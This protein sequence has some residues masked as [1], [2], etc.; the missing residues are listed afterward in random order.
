MKITTIKLS[1]NKDVTLTAYVQ[2]QSEEMKNMT[3]KKAILIFPGGG[4]K[5]CSDREAEPI[6]LL[7]LSKGYNAFILRYSVKEHAKWPK[8]LEDA[9]QAMAYLKNHSLELDIDQDRIAVIGFSAGGHLASQL[10]TSGINRPN[11]LILGYPAVLRDT[12]NG[13]DYPK[14]IVDDKTPEAFVFHTVEDDVV[15]QK[16]SLY[17]ANAFAEKK[18][19]LELHIFRNGP[20]GLSIGN[21]ITYNNWDRWIEKDYQN[22]FPLSIAWL[23]KVL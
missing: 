1:D 20:H 22:W 5:F 11:A 8:P 18:I 7:Y 2:D 23:E 19:P 4:Y 16:Q 10:A 12:M 9:E 3:K 15:S 17:L 13:F 21:E 6:A 14:P